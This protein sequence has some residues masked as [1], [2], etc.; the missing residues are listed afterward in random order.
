MTQPEYGEYPQQPPATGYPYSGGNFGSPGP[1][2][3]GQPPYPTPGYGAPQ[4]NQYPQQPGFPG[5]PIQQS[6]GLGTAGFVVGL[7]GFLASI[8]FGF[9]AWILVLPGLV[10]SAIGIRREPK[11]LAIAGLVL[12]ILGLIICVVWVV[13]LIVASSN[14]DAPYRYT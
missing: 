2:P 5:G 7:L 8:P 6:N 14:G 4:W 12:S 10:L 11:G 1:A 13:A 3:Y 9:L